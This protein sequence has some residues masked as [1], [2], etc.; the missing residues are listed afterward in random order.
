[1]SD[2]GV[3]QFVAGYMSAFEL[4][5]RNTETGERR[6]FTVYARDAQGAYAQGFVKLDTESGDRSWC[7]DGYVKRDT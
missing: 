4:H 2:F 1:M 7:F 5:A 3:R 6:R